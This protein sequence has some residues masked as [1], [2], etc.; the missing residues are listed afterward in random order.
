VEQTFS[1]WQPP[2]GVHTCLGWQQ[3]RAHA[4]VLVPFGQV[5]GVHAPHDLSCCTILFATGIIALRR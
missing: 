2:P 3:A 4:P 5:S 1:V